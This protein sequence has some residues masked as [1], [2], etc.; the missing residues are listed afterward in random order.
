MSDVH[1]ALVRRR[2][3]DVAVLF[4]DVDD[5]KT[6][7]DVLGHAAGDELLTRVAAQLRTAVRPSDTVA[8]LG[9]DEFSVLF[10]DLGNQAEVEHVAERILAGLKELVVLERREISP[11]ASIGI[12]V[13][14]SGHADPDELMRNAD[15]AMYE[16]KRT[17]KDRYVVFHAG[18]HNAVL[19][20]LELEID[21]RSAVDTAEGLFLEFQP[22][23][24]VQTNE[25]LGAEALVRWN[26]PR[27][28]R[29]G[30]LDFIP[31]AE[32]TGLTTPLGDW[33]LREACAQ[34]SLWGRNGQGRAPYISVN[35]SVHQL[36][37]TTFPDRVGAVL[38]QTGLEPVRLML[39]LTESVVMQDMESNIAQLEALKRLGVRLAIDDFGTGYSSLNYLRRLPVDTVK[40]DRAF[41]QQVDSEAEDSAVARAIVQLAKSFNLRTVAE[42]IEENG[43]LNELA[44]L[45]CD[46]GQ[47]FLFAPPLSL[48]RIQRLFA[49]DAPA[50][51]L[52][53]AESPV[54]RS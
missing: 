30:P 16:A 15:V 34:A 35:V 38:A 26:H 23:Y 36:K 47:G 3:G 33:V 14:G 54:F 24:S 48:D 12:A 18:M 44:A 29:I 42:G 51:T 41:V 20:R 9:G 32:D 2:R 19:A 50:E 45:G 53:A 49:A 1:H 27:R 4:L 25:I 46:A 6:V 52:R 8:R 21:V 7:N 10:E 28:G 39:E 5:F 43:Q 17:G 11:R 37:E 31:L 13:A 40:I 22:I